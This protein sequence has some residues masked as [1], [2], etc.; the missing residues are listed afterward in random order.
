MRRGLLL[1]LMSKI[2]LLLRMWLLLG[3]GLSPVGHPGGVTHLFEGVCETEKKQNKKK[4]KK[5]VLDTVSK[6][7]N[8]ADVLIQ[9]ILDIKKKTTTDVLILYQK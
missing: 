5:D 9:I 2:R 1:L 7:N 6:K 4:T 8:H 3:V